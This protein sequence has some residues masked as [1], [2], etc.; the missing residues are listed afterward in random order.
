[1]KL[2]NIVISILM[3]IALIQI[4]N[5]AGIGVAPSILEFKDALKG[6][7][8]EKEFKIDN[9]GD[10]D[11]IAVI[12]IMNLT[13]WFILEPGTEVKVPA[14]GSSKVKT[15]I[16][17]PEDT[18]NGGYETMIYVKGKPADTTE[19]MGLIPGAGFK[20][21]ITV[22]DQEIIEGYVDNILTRDT[23]L[24]GKVNFIIGFLN[25]GNVEAS[26]NAKI[27]IKTET[28]ELI[29]SFE[30]QFK[31]VKAWAS[32][33]LIAEY[34]TKGKALGKYKADVQVYLNNELLEEKTV[35][36]KIL[37]ELP[38]AIEEEPKEAAL[39][40]EPKQE[41]QKEIKPATTATAKGKT[42]IN[43]GL[44]LATVLI[45]GIGIGLG[46]GVANAVFKRKK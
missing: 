40:E 43:A 35:Y 46:V 41:P 2:V 20:A 5:A 44:V 22:T 30:K 23:T 16:D 39:K 10:G 32:E 36:F 33:S 11:I 1:M 25:K 12:E 3:C 7:S 9:T 27:A 8:Y 37:E 14:K 34:D 29:G 42:K 26:P 6:S 28:D 45:L 18:P 21:K 24:N 31:A 17:I 15:T 13:D 4:V 19:G 38:S